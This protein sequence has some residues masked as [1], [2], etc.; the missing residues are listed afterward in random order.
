MPFFQAGRRLD[1]MYAPVTTPLQ[2]RPKAEPKLNKLVIYFF[3]SIMQPYARAL[4]F[5][6]PTIL[7][8]ER[9]VD[10]W[11]AFNR[12]ETRM[13]IGFRH[14]YG[15]DPQM[16]AYTIHHALPKAARKIGKPLKGLT[17]T[18]FIYGAE[19]PLWSG[20][21][22]R[23]LL[24]EAGAIPVDHVRMD[25]SGMALI[26]RLM[27]EGAF[28]I[29]LA[30]EGHVTHDSETV[31]DLETGTA[32]FCFWCQ[33][34]LHKLGRTE[35]VVFL[36]LSFHY[37]Y[38]QKDWKKLSRFCSDMEKSIG[39]P[40]G[41]AFGKLDTLK[42]KKRIDSLS[43]AIIFRL[44]QMYSIEVGS[45][46]TEEN[47]LQERIL[48]EALGQAEGIAHIEKASTTMARIYRIRAKAWSHIIKDNPEGTN[49]LEKDI[50]SRRC[51]EAWLAMRH[52]ETASILTHVQFLHDKTT[53]T[54][55]RL[56]ERA[57]NCYDIIERMRG[58]TLKNRAN[59]FTK[60]AI[61]VPGQAIEMNRFR[62]VYLEDKKTALTE[63]TRAIQN[64]FR[65]CITEYRESVGSAKD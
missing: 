29:A 32:R 36:P 52:L 22:V 13:I 1:Y 8:P 46:Q 28:P 10:A 50:L 26:R 49:P 34:D 33:D 61:I 14:A 40:Q 2:E 55:E 24:P 60:R 47:S 31:G 56:I 38:A 35:S 6:E 7:F 51:L 64:S 5:A 27:I 65:E 30:P 16:T 37:R 25:S 53:P 11:H 63:A 59:R 42:A 3:R 54:L 41:E 12:K 48:E 19:V 45:E 15:D 43:R 39:E 58:G 9:I 23:W 17:H 62:K 21:F 44:A 20:P 57:N 18:H 4:G